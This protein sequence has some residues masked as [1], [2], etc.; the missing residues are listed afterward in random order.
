[1]DHSI[2][3]LLKTDRN[4]AFRQLYE[5]AFAPVAR[6]VCRMGGSYPD[7]KDI[8][9]DALIILYEKV[10]EGELSLQS[11]VNAYVLGICKHLWM[12]QYRQDQHQLPLSEVE[13]VITIPEDYPEEKTPRNTIRKV[14]EF[15]GQKCMELLQA[16]Y[17]HRNSMQEIAQQFGYTSSRSA[18]VQKFKCLEKVRSKVK[19][20]QLDY[21]AFAS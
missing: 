14:L 21:E 7:A 6:F 20:N 16:F 2:I 10:V 13:A 1:M 5:E 18:T 3:D 9:H 4:R 11:S 8:F 15:A 17:Y 12:R 19:E